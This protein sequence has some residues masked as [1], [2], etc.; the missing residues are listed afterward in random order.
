MKAIFKRELNAYFDSPLGYVFIAV[1]YLFAGY[2]FLSY[3]LYGNTTDMSALFDFMFTVTLFL[4]P[5]LT[6]RLMSE[7][8]KTKTDQLLLM[9]PVTGLAI[10][11]G[12]FLAAVAVFLCAIAITLIMA[13]VMSVY[14]AP[15]WPVVFGHFIGLFLL[16][17]ALIAAGLLISALTENQ[18]IAAVGGFC[19]GFFLMALDGISS[20]LGGTAL[21]GFVTELSFQTRYR[22]F[23]L[24]VFDVSDVVFFASITALFLYFTVVALERRRSN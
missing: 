11:L 12:K 1:Y 19:L 17:A 13:C 2:F 23:T 22:S 18:I 5:I 16:G 6:M 20:I 15:D 7:D 3:N 14:A 24:G 21:A 10:I 9:A 8:R 4:V